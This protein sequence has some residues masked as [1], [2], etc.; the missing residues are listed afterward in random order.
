M[1]IKNVICAMLGYFFACSCSLFLKASFFKV[2]TGDK[3]SFEF[4][5]F[6]GC[7]L[8]GFENKFDWYD[9]F[10]FVGLYSEDESVVINQVLDFHF[11]GMKPSR[12]DIVIKFENS[13]EGLGFG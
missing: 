3:A 13:F 11:D 2:A 5:K 6:T 10:V 1:R 12:S 4:V 9:K 7:G 8:F